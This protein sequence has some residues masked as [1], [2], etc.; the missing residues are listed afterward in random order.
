MK[1]VESV[2]TIPIRMRVFIMRT[3]GASHQFSRICRG[4]TASGGTCRGRTYDQSVM[5][6]NIRIELI[7][8]SRSIQTFNTADCSTSELM[9]HIS[10]LIYV[11]MELPT[12]HRCDSAGFLHPSSCTYLRN[13]TSRREDPVFKFSQFYNLKLPN[14]LIL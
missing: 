11:L 14:Q 8:I 1:S 6:L 9:S 2:L 4:V 7:T 12:T 5:A 13:F 3:F 10:Q